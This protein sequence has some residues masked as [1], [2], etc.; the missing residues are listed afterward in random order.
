MKVLL[1]ALALSLMLSCKGDTPSKNLDQQNQKG[2]EAEAQTLIQARQELKTKLTHPGDKAGPIDVPPPDAPFSLVQ[3]DA[4]PGKL[5]A[6]LTKDPK[7]KKR[8]PAIIWITGGDSNSLGEMWNPAPKNNDQTA[9]AY[10]QAGIV[11]MLPSLRGGNE[12]PGQREGFLGE[13][14]DVLSALAYLKKVPY[15]DPSRIYLGG[16]STG[17]TLVLLVAEVSN[18]FRTVF[19]FGPVADVRVY[20]DSYAYADINENQEALPRSPGYWL[21]DIKTPAFVMEGSRGNSEQLNAMAKSTSNSQ[22]HFLEI[23]NTDHFGILAP[24][25]E[26]IA[27]QIVKDTGP[28]PSI[29]LSKVAL[30]ALF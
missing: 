14:D 8:H 1:P 6:Y 29:R 19:S 5:S 21:A 7:D 15:V 27:Q 17:G 4:Q 10:R 22:V 13:V 30:E 2:S 24:V 20:G 23:H 16:H 25:N 9:A 26:A 11:M 12:N 18:A 28:T 3:F